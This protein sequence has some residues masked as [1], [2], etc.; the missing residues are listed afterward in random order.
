MQHTVLQVVVLSDEDEEDL[1]DTD[2]EEEDLESTDEGSDDEEFAELLAEVQTEEK[3]A[4]TA[5]PAQV[6]QQKD[7]RDM[8]ILSDGLKLMN[9]AN[10]L[11]AKGLARITAV[12]KRSPNLEALNVA[13]KPFQ[14]V[15]VPDVAR[16]VAP[17][18]PMWSYSRKPTMFMEKIGPVLVKGSKTK[19]LCP[20][21]PDM[22]PMLWSSCDSHIRK[23]HTKQ[24]YG[25][26]PTCGFGSYNGDSQNKHENRCKAQIARKIA[27]GVVTET[28]SKPPEGY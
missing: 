3:A 8:K 5:E 26:C 9:K 16:S 27:K 4:E 13:L 22:E 2:E 15:Y 23:E 19:Y 18:A 17:Y 12:V 24:M 7:A 10:K 6:L 20:K 21:C 28:V 14:N 11:Q 25:P 1:G